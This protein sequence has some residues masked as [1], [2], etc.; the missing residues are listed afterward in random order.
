MSSDNK[1]TFLNDAFHTGYGRIISTVAGVD[2][3]DEG[4]TA[5]CFTFRV[6]GS[7]TR[8]YVFN[9]DTSGVQ[10]AVD[11][12]NVDA[13][14]TDETDK[15]T[16]EYPRTNEELEVSS[17]ENFWFLW[18]EKEKDVDPKD[19]VEELEKPETKSQTSIMV[20]GIKLVITRHSLGR[21]NVKFSKNGDF[22][23]GVK[24]VCSE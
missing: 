22:P 24:L 14:T 6:P 17:C 12:V 20:A 3:P 13:L 15:K 8:L 4:V 19:I 7:T 2:N 16:V 1:N 10:C 18:S 23:K 21:G 9:T 5:Y 11:K